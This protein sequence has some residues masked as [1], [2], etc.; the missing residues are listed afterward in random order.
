MFYILVPDPTGSVNGN[1][2]TKLTVSNIVVGTVGHEY[3]HLINASRRLYVLNLPSDFEEVWLNEG[4]SHIAEELI[5]YRSAGLTPRQNI[6]TTVI[7]SP[8][9]LNAFSRFMN[10]NNGR[11]KQYLSSTESQAPISGDDD[12]PTR[13]A[14]WSFLRYMADLKRPGGDGDFWFQLV[15]TPLTGTANLQHVIGGDQAPY[16]RD[17]ATSVYTDDF[18]PNVAA[19]YAQASWNTRQAF[20]NPNGSFPLVTRTMTD[21]VKAFVN[22]TGGGVSFLR[23]TVSNGQQTFITVTGPGGT[24]LPSGVQLSVVRNK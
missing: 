18:A 17:W 6:G 23:L 3:Q 24:A 16:L 21:D 9:V 14:I 22:L 10:G 4:L 15:N 8:S 20:L 2:R 11:Y 19:R 5:F 12:L 1:I 13:G 7:N